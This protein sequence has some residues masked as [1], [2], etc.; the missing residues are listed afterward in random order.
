MKKKYIS[1]F[2]EVVLKV[3]YILGSIHKE[4]LYFTQFSTWIYWKTGLAVSQLL[5]MLRYWKVQ[6]FKTGDSSNK[7][8]M[9]GCSFQQLYGKIWVGFCL[10]TV[11]RFV[12]EKEHYWFFW[13][14]VKRILKIALVTS[15]VPFLLESTKA[16]NATFPYEY[17]GKYKM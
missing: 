3:I 10:S 12:L 17:N 8:K 4:K 15:I 11:K 13:K 7:Q 1:I 6:M 14:L 16:E 5:H 9:D 2:A